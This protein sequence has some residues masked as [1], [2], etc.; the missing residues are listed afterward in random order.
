M[1]NVFTNVAANMD[2]TQVPLINNEALY[3]QQIIQAEK[4]AA[5]QKTRYDAALGF[6]NVTNIISD[7]D[8]LDKQMAAKLTKETLARAETEYRA[9]LQRVSDLGFCP[10]V[11]CSRQRTKD[12]CVNG[13]PGPKAR[14]SS[15]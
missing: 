7:Q 11:S 3:C 13:V 8:L 1:A 4:D 5:H 9:A 2:L 6:V 12:V 10:L 15:S 14:T